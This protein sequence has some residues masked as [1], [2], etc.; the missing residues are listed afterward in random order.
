M[1]RAPRP[2]PRALAM[3][4]AVAALLAATA[5]GAQEERSAD[6]P[7]GPAAVVGHLVHATRPEATANVDVLLYA[8]SA[9]GNA[10]LRQTTSD[11]EGRFR[12]QGVSNEPGVVYL[13][14]AREGGVPFG[15]RFAFAPGELEHSVELEIS[16]AVSDTGVAE[17][18]DVEIR[19]ERGCTHLHFQHS[20]ALR[21]PSSEVLFVPAAERAK[22][23][24]IFEVELPEAAEGFESLAGSEGLVLEGRRLRFWGPLY[25]GSQ[26]IEFGYGLPIDSTSARIGL[27]DGAPALLVLAPREVLSVTSD[28]LSS[29]PDVTE[30]GRVLG[31][32]RSGA[33]APGPLELAIHTEP[34]AV[35]EASAPVRTQRAELW[36]EL[37]DAALEVNERVVLDVEG[38]GEPLVSSGAPLL[39]LP[40]PAG[41]GSLRFSPETLEAGLRRDPSGDLAIQ[42]P[43]P[44]GPSEL[45]LSY[46]L[47]ATGSGA[48]LLQRFDRELPLL[49]VLVADNG[50]IAETDRLHRRRPVRM[51]ERTYQHLEAF[52]VEPLETVAISLLRTA[53]RGEE[54]RWAS[55]G[56]AVFA[57]LAALL[58]LTAP[59]RGGAA[60]RREEREPD[61]ASLERAAI[62]RSLQDLDEDLETGKLTPEDHAAMRSELRSRAAAVLF[63]PSPAPP[64]PV[65]PA[66]DSGAPARVEAVGTSRS[67]DAVALCGQ[68]GAQ[69]EA[70]HRFCTRCGA[71]LVC[72]AC[73]ARFRPNDAFC[74]QCGE[75]LASGA[76]GA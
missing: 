2:A 71:A 50:V 22:A 60:A 35:A 76:D 3:A 70:E 37:D 54:G 9:D 28:V 33:F 47:P 65:T 6:V 21:N 72:T 75:K 1:K 55:A 46:R 40:L 61:G 39:C 74:S 8:L 12:F 11:A 68:C 58:F 29:A 44:R 15:A 64:A 19:I 42:G 66:A 30:D 41:A 16:D 49:S 36:L 14:G 67:T 51:D 69:P 31:A 73:G 43:L 34:G 27:P 56:F 48:R 57:G 59:L 26:T 10:G 63:A 32:Q 5:I 23:A 45:A 7:S 52:A 13:I 62:V 18:G 38:N 53:P 24:P 25:P 20:H 4:I 17:A